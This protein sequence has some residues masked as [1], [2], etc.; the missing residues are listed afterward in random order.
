VAAAAVRRQKAPLKNAQKL[1]EQSQVV[2]Q[3]QKKT[4]EVDTKPKKTDK[5]ARTVNK[6]KIGKTKYCS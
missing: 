3:P 2:E 4:S 5:I 6:L 1:A